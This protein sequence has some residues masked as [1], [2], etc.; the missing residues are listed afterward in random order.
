MTKSDKQWF[1][2]AKITKSYLRYPVIKHGLLENPPFS[3]MIVPSLNLHLVQFGDFPATV[4]DT[5]GYMI[6][7]PRIHHKSTMKD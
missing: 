4:D 3:S 5:G 2:Y 6:S 1:K 7:S